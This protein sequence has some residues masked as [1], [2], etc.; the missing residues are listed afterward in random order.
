MIPAGLPIRGSADPAAP[1]GAMPAGRS[2][3]ATAAPALPAE[4]R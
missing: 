3:P 2:R 1:T 4:L